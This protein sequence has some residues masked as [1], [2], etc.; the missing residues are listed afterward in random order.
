[1]LKGVLT[2]GTARQSLA[3]FPFPAAG[4]TGTQTA[5]TNSWFVGSTPQLTT[6]VWVGDP[7]G[8]THMVNIPEF[9]ADGVPN[10][11]GGTYPARIWGAMME[12][13]VTPLPLEDWPA[14]PDPARKP[15]RLYLPGYECL[16][17]LVSGALP[18]PPGSPT[19]TAAPTTTTLPVDPSGSTPPTTAAPKPVLKV[20]PS[21]TTI[22]PDV[23]DPKAPFPTVPIAGT[24]VYL[25][26]K[27]P[28]GVV[29]SGKSKTATTTTTAGP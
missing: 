8:Y 22:P 9:V 11:Q 27:P 24:I 23:L 19:T 1:V 4:K 28:A 2:K 3:K 17:K 26:D 15:V 13:A 16:A 21:D 7:D 20:I 25:C 5:N 6:A 14:P 10:V 29:I 18:L 12:P